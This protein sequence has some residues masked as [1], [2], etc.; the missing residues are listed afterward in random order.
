MTDVLYCTLYLCNAYMCMHS[1][2]PSSSMFRFTAVVR[3]CSHSVSSPTFSYLDTWCCVTQYINHCFPQIGGNNKMLSNNK[4]ER[5]RVLKN[6]GCCDLITRPICRWNCR[7]DL[8]WFL[9]RTIWLVFYAV[10]RNISLFQCWQRHGE[11]TLGS[12]RRKPITI[13]RLS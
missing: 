7:G 2:C 4:T 5:S 1:Y 8:R 11:R 3:R 9:I 10:L 6:V 12:T 13:Y